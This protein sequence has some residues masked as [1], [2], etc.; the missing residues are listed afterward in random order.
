MPSPEPKIDRRALLTGAGRGAL[1]VLA[2]TLVAGSASACG[3]R[4][5]P[6]VDP[7]QTQLDFAT[8]DAEL[9]RTVATAAAPGPTRAL[10]RVA[11]EREEHAQALATEIARAAGVT[12]LPTTSPTSTPATTTGITGPQAPPPSVGDVVAALRRSAI[13]A[14]QLVPSLSGYR[15]GLLASI[16]AACTASYTVSLRTERPS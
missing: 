2:A 15:A 16:A 11:T 3:A 13:S 8:A 6:E 7:L 4:D 1:G 9:A 14:G 12:S 5:E 10:N